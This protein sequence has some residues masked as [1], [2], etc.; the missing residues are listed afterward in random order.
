MS[1]EVS[2]N[3]GIVVAHTLH[4]CYNF[5]KSLQHRGRGAAGIAARRH[6]GGGIDVV[7]WTGLVD[8]FD[9]TDFHKIF[10]GHDYHTFLGH[11]RYPSRGRRELKQILEDAHPHV[12]GGSKTNHGDHVILRNCDAAI[13]H[14]GQINEKFL[15]AVNKRD[16]SSDCDSEIFL[17]YVFNFGE[18]D[19][20]ENIPGA[21]TAAVAYR[22]RD[23]VII[24]R[25]ILG[26]H[27]GVLGIKGGK[28]CFASEDTALINN[29]AD[30]KEDLA[31]GS[32]YHIR[33]NG[34]YWEEKI[35]DPSNKHCF[36]EHNYLLNRNSVVNGLST[37][38]LREELG[39]ELAKEFIPQD[40]DIVTFIPRCPEPAAWAYYKASGIPFKNIFYKQHNE[41]SF[42]E[43][44]SKERESSINNN[45]YLLPD[46][47]NEIKGKNIVV[48]EDSIVRGNVI[49]KARDLLHEEAGIKK[50]YIL[51]YTPP[52]C[53]SNEEGVLFG[54]EFGVDMPPIPAKGD[55]YIARGRTIKEINEK[56]GMSIYY[57]SKEGMFR[58]FNKF[59]KS[60]NDLCSFCI[61]GPHPFDIL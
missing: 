59:G 6:G 14:N 33:P 53:I 61:G 42:M 55:E 32:V 39:K 18:H 52:V 2:H 3:C 37:R 17:H 7:K 47:S 11:V 8:K 16:I 57:L 23:D 41:R 28:Y 38:L 45:L 29:G 12:I 36:F 22:H 5:L 10:P 19:T 48:I 30:P 49:R 56:A 21:Y 34:D 44:T 26:M 13:V 50:A 9:I 27:P 1:E 40:A 24:L 15:E 25:D 35:G 46:I 4:D 31:P 60:E 43:A 54:C 58:A 51:S 20:I